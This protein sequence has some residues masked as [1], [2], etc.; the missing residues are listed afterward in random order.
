MSAEDLEITKKPGVKKS[1]IPTRSNNEKGDIF[2]SS[3]N[4]EEEN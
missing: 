4:E 2:G 3:E 1:S